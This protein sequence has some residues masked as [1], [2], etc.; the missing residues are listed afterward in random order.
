MWHRLRFDWFFRKNR[1]APALAQVKGLYGPEPKRDQE[2]WAMYRLG[3]YASVA[4]ARPGR[5]GW[6]GAFARAVSCAAAGDAAASREAQ[7]CFLRQREAPIH[8]AELADAL[9]P[10]LPADALRLVEGLP[11]VSP[12]LRVAILLRNGEAEAARQLL[13][14]LPSEAFRV[15]PELSLYQTNACGGEPAVQLQRLNAFLAHH[16]VAPLRLRDESLPPSP[17]NLA[18]ASVPAPVD[19]PLVSV[20]MTTFRTGPRAVSAIE[21]VLAQSY[22]NLELIVVDDASGDDTPALVA[23]LAAREARVR[24]IPLPRNVGTYV[25]KTIGL[26]RARG[27]FVTCHDSDDWSHPEK[28]AR[29]VA[30]LL[31]EPRLVASVSTW[32]RQQ[33]DGLFYARPVHPLA[34]LN[35]SSPLFRRGRVLKEMGAWDC[36]RTGADSEFLARLKLVFGPKAVRKLR[37]PLALGS[38]RPDSLMTAAS[39]GF[40]ESGLSPQRLAYWE[41]WTRWHIETLAAGRKPFLPADVAA[42]VRQRPFEVPEGLRVDPA[43]VDACLAALGTGRGPRS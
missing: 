23:G 9:A 27:E 16:G 29:Q 35:P 38:H 12:A 43:A 28:I 32:V 8:Q 10:F 20:L 34:R 37:E 31:A 4:Q 36:V 42:A 11:G 7:A 19:G 15:H 3:M 40:S 30:P 14:Q 17:R 21:S 24:F 2:L 26:A 6:R 13:A 22:R 39:T 25:A 41:A 5:L 33:D 18:P 1:F